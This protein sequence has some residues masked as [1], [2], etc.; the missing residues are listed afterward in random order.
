MTA[1]IDHPD[2]LAVLVKCKLFYVDVLVLKTQW[3]SGDGL[4]YQLVYRLLTE[5]MR[6]GRK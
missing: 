6:T 5:L 1:S 4:L 3:R 2:G